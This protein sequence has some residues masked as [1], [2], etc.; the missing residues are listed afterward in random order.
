M[1]IEVLVVPDC[2]HEKAAVQRLRQALD[3]VGLHD[4]EVTTRVITD[5]AAAERCGFTGSPTILV[6][7]RD[8]FATIGARPGVA[9]RVYAT[10]DGLVG[11]PPLDALRQ[12]LKDAAGPSR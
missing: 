1:E 7:G 5:Q 10:A 9:C 6:D 4:A 11:V 12:A 2:P 8:P 3:D